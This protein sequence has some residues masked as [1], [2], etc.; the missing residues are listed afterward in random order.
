MTA[1]RDEP[2]DAEVV[3][4]PRTEIEWPEIEPPPGW[5]QRLPRWRRHDD[6]PPEA[7]GA[8]VV[9][10]HKAPP[11][12]VPLT[13]ERAPSKA[14]AVVAR[15]TDRGLPAPR[16]VAVSAGWWARTLAQIVPWLPVL[17]VKELRPILRGIGRVA[18]WWARI[19]AV[20][21]L[22]EAAKKAEGNKHSADM[23]AAHKA[24]ASRV[25]VSIAI[26]LAVVGVTWWQLVVHPWA[27]AGVGVALLALFDL[28]G[29]AGRP[30]EEQVF[31]PTGPIVE[32]IPLSSLRAEIARSF[33]EQGIEATI[34][35]PHPAEHGWTVDYHTRAAVEDEHLRQVERDLNVRRNGITQIMERGRAAVGTLH[36]MLRDPLARV[37]DSPDPGELSIYQP[38]PLG[39]TASGQEWTEHLLRTHFTV[40]GASQSGKSSC[41]WQFTDVLRRC[42]EQE[43]DAIDL[44]EGPAFGAS[45]R[46]FRQRAFD[47]ES[48]LRVLTEAV[49]LCK[50]RN[51]E[52][53]RLAEDDDTPDDY[54]EKWQPTPAE[55]QRTVLIDEFARV[56]ENKDLLPLVEYLLRYGAKAAVT[57]GIAGQGATLA[58][59]GT[60][61]VR[62][63]VM[64]KVMFACGRD[65]VL[66][67]FGKDARNSGYRPDL[68]EPANGASINDAGKC[69]VMS[70]MSRTAEPRRA[71]RLEQAEVRRRDREL[72]SRDRADVMTIDAVEVPPALGAVEAAFRAAD[73]P[74]R[75]ATKELL[76]WLRA[77]GLELDEQALADRLRPT[78]LRPRDKRWRPTPGANAVRGYYLA[79]V[80]AA[81]RRLS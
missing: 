67:L 63:Q 70:S 54:D 9:Q 35:M 20:K 43:L 22:F 44:T 28:I 58:D 21:H 2:V 78:G 62:G 14:R 74:E 8:Q 34:A 33:E 75:M 59:F 23:K 40:I 26:V 15:V 10:L 18:S 48:A 13:V 42:P 61:V 4:E 30:A 55:P 1:A 11:A 5:W 69:Y 38:L 60:S 81:I 57:V 24:Q 46:A 39:V 25:V 56:A 80:Q 6:E 72:G 29:R 65:D 36:V 68:L 71:Y 31:L 12:P 37:V 79:D 77:G 73:D 3:E 45:R 51:A 64:L 7:P 76:A 47:E 27:V 32:G 52:L 16:Q 66:W 41:F 50:T 49:A 19:V 53:N 17:I